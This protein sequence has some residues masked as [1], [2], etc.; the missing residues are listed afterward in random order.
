VVERFDVHDS[1][2]MKPEQL[3]RLVRDRLLAAGAVRSA[4]YP[5]FRVQ[6]PTGVSAWQSDE[7]APAPSHAAISE[8]EQAIG[9]ILRVRALTN[10]S[11]HALAAW[12]GYRS[13]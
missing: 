7:P 13:I 2:R 8:F 5:P 4:P 6:G 1:R 11:S 9:S 10:L 3:A 12:Y